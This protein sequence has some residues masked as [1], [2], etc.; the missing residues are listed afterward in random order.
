MLNGIIG[1]QEP[2]YLLNVLLIHV[3]SMLTNFINVF[4]HLFASLEIESI[5]L[6]SIHH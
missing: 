6:T 1:E 3:V 5:Q 2:L 4:I